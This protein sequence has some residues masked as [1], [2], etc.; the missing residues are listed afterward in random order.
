M[1]DVVPDAIN[2]MLDKLVQ[3]AIDFARAIEGAPIKISLRR[4]VKN[5]ILSVENKGS[6]LPQNSKEI[7]Q[8]F[9]SMVS[10]RS[11]ESHEAHL[12]LGLYIARLIAEFHGGTIAAANLEDGS[13]VIFWVTLPG[14]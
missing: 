7:A 3:N 14:A 4:D 8:L 5:I 1:C 2:Q 9:D 11:V 12:G 13:G 10:K 6:L